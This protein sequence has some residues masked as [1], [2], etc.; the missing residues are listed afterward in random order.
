MAEQCF[1]DCPELFESLDESHGYMGPCGDL[2]TDS[3]DEDEP[4]IPEEAAAVQEY[5]AERSRILEH[6]NNSKDTC[7][8]PCLVYLIKDRKPYLVCPITPGPYH[9]PC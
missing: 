5:S 1:L 4:I 9:L 2:S 6:I 3:P 7:E 8:G